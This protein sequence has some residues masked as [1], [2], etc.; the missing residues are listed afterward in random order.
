MRLLPGKQ[1]EVRRYEPDEAAGVIAQ[2]EAWQTRF[3]AERGE[4][5]FHLGDE[6]Y[7]MIR[8]EVPEAAIYDGYPQLE[9]GIGITRHLLENLDRYLSRSRPG[10]LAGADGTVACGTVIGPTMQ[11]IV[12][13]FNGRT[14]ARLHVVVVD[15]EFFGT[16]INVSGLLTGG[17]LVRA[18][19]TLGGRA[20]IYISS[21]MISDRTHTLLDDMTIL[22]LRSSL[23]RAVVP[24]LTM[25]DVAR[26]MRGRLRGQRAA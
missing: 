4:T 9:D 18:L 6:F 11:G 13:R 20:P 22:E 15:N 5:F 14:G 23:R 10:S 26:D 8:R 19:G 16:E 25:S 7:L 1:I 21:R 2:A 17:D 24:A 12:D 3:R